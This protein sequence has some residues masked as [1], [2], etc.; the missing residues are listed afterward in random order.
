MCPDYHVK[1][2]FISMLGDGFAISKLHVFM[3]QLTF[4]TIAL[5]YRMK[6]STSISLR[7]TTNFMNGN[8]SHIGF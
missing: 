1:Q 6:V 8:L 2:N 4:N 7:S 3:L 5:S